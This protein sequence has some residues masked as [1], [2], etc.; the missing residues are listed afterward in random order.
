MLDKNIKLIINAIYKFFYFKPI[1]MDKKKKN[2]ILLMPIWSK[3]I[4]IY[5]KRLY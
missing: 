1:L 5:F 3:N 4:E 2:V